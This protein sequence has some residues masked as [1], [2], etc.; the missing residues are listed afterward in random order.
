MKLVRVEEAVGMALCHDMTRIVPGASKGPQFQKGHIIRAEDIPLLLSM[1]KE[2][3]YVLEVQPGMVHEEE[4]AQRIARAVAGSGLEQTAPREGK[5]DLVAAHDGLLRIDAQRLLRLNTIEDVQ[6]AT[7]PDLYP[8][9]AG[10]RV[11]GTRVVPLLVPD[12]V[13]R[14]AEGLGAEGPVLQVKPYRP[15]PAAV[16]VT[17]SEVYKGR[18][19]DAF[20]PVVQKKMQRF[21]CQ[22]VYT[23]KAPDDKETIAGHITAAVAAGAELVCCCGGM[24]VDPDDAT[25]GAI[26]R[27]GAQVV[28]YGTPV[29][30]GSMLLLAYLQGRAVLGLPGAVMHDPIT[31]FDLILCRLLA[32]ETLT[33]HDI[34]AM[35]LGGY[36]AQQPGRFSG[37]GI[38][39][40]ETGG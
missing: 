6:M 36:L 38:A 13:V 3:I 29:L 7:L 16:I 19:A 18:I 12:A 23:A 17:G 24:S 8:V 28:S 31:C 5:V 26:R 33:R 30:P 34:A 27:S 4:A 20:G 2:H 37:S 25:P 35:G 10:K 32:D 39:S 21:G 15:R 1:G 40:D 11:A 22:V 14:Q 9:A